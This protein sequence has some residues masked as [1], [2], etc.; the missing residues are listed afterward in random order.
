MWNSSR[1][2]R[3]LA[4]KGC[5]L[6]TARKHPR[7]TS[8]RQFFHCF[9]CGEKGDVMTLLEKM[10]TASVHGRAARFGR[11]RRRAVGRAAFLLPSARRGSEVRT[12]PDVAARWSWRPPSSRSS[13]QAGGAAR[14]Y[15]EGR[16]RRRR[17]ARALPRS[18]R[19]R[20]SGTRCRRTWR[21]SDPLGPVMEQLGSLG[22]GTTALRL[23]PRPRDAAGAQNG[24]EA[25]DGLRRAAGESRGQRNRKCVNSS[26]SPLGESALRAARGA[27][28]EM[29]AGRAGRSHGRKLRRSGAPPAHIEEALAPMG[30]ALTTEQLKLSQEKENHPRP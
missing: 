3:A 9:G 4:G 20:V 8:T 2:V 27:G 11:H 18:G 13:T 22:A 6:F 25:R 19:P 30:T 15:V 1:Q 28:R 5:A 14:A 21:T 24:A 26:D 7:S 23:L 16:G 12:Q 17:G 29:R 10:G